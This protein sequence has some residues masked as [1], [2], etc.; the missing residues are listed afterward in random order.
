MLCHSRGRCLSCLVPDSWFLQ[1]GSQHPGGW[2]VWPPAASHE[3][4]AVLQ[5]FKTK[6][7][8]DQ[9]CS[10][11]FRPS[12]HP[13]Q[14]ESQPQLTEDGICSDFSTDLQSAQI[15]H[16]FSFIAIKLTRF[17]DATIFLVLYVGRILS[18]LDKAIQAEEPK[19]VLSSVP[20]LLSLHLCFIESLCA[21]D[22]ALKLIASYQ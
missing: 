22:S 14:Y 5:F 18:L 21:F 10:L 1:A 3:G 17:S 15:C 4:G 20:V 16:L 7:F 12:N 9:A 11:L 8:L 19:C 2:T 6:A 13:L